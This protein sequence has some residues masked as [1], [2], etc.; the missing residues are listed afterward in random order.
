MDK[1]SIPDKCEQT[2]QQVHTTK[3]AVAIG[4]PILLADRTNVTPKLF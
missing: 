4:Q 3:T 1:I 2:S